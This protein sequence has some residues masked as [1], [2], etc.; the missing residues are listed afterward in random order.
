MAPKDFPAWLAKW[1]TLP[2]IRRSYHLVNLLTGARPG[3]LALTPWTNVDP[4]SRTLTI[5]NGKKGNDIPIPI[6]GPIARAL[7]IARDHAD[8]S[9][10]IF[11]GC[12]QAGHHEDIFAKGERGHSHRRTWKTVAVECEII[13][14]NSALVLGHVP[15][16]TSAKY[17]IRKVLLEGKKLRGYQA[18]ISRAMLEYFGTDPTL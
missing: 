6:R 16:G 1:R 14:E 17:A 8:G 4:C 11:P 9:G 5:G 15:P 7:K 3:E 2:P 12:E 13:D 10:L 18:T